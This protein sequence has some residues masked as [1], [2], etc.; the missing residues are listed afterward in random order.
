MYKIFNFFSTKKNQ[1][2]FT[3]EIQDEDGKKRRGIFD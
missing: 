3:N 1:W 2:H